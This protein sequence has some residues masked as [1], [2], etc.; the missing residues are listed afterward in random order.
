MAIDGRRLRPH[1]RRR[2]GA[3][4]QV[5]DQGIEGTRDGDVSPTTPSAATAATATPA[6][7]VP[8]N[9]S[10]AGPVAGQ[11]ASFTSGVSPGYPGFSSVMNQGAQQVNSLWLKPEL[12]PLLIEILFGINLIFLLV[13]SLLSLWRATSWGSFPSADYYA[14]M[15]QA[16]SYQVTLQSFD[17]V[18]SAQAG[19]TMMKFLGALSFAAMYTYLMLRKPL[20]YGHIREA[21]FVL[22]ISSSIILFCIIMTLWLMIIEVGIGSYIIHQLDWLPFSQ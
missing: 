8:P 14:R 15:A 1:P 20:L 4:G 12:H 6:T 19:E 2:L 11:P 5:G 9:A 18:R 13:Y 7:P 21:A 16:L 17:P 3:R 10:A 22:L